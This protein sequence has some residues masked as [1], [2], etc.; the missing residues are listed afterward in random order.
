MPRGFHRPGHL[1]KLKKSLYGLRQAPRLWGEF[2]KKNLEAVGF[3]QAVDVDACLFISDKVICLTY[4]D[5]TLFFA[6]DIQ[7]IDD[8]IDL[9]R[10]QQKMTLDIE[11]DVAGFLGCLL[12][13]S[14]AADE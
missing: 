4:V 8:V 10:D 7:D 13:T 3:E 1:L 5:D 9:L 12:Y 2:L 14:D 11:D 6:K